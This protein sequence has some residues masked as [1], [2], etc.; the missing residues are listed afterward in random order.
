MA[1][2][3]DTSRNLRQQ[4]NN[5]NSSPRSSQVGSQKRK[6][7]VVDLTS[8]AEDSPARKVQRNSNASHRVQDQPIN[9]NSDDDEDDGWD[10]LGASTQDIGL[11]QYDDYTQFGVLDTK[12]VGIRY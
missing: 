12:I 9:V 3:K 7:D 5:V 4:D 8:D 6:A 2:G 1:R 11:S 10:D